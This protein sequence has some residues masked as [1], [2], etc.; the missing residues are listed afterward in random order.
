MAKRKK[1]F[2]SRKRQAGPSA[3][4]AIGLPQGITPA[5]AKPSRRRTAEDREAREARRLTQARWKARGEW[6]A[7]E[8]E[9]AMTARLAQR[10]STMQGKDYQV[11][12]DVES[13]LRSLFQPHEI[14]AVEYSCIGLDRVARVYGVERAYMCAYMEGC[15]QGFIEGRLADLKPRRARSLKANAAKRTKVQDCGGHMMTLDERDAAIVTQYPQLRQMLGSIDA[16][17]RLAEKYGLMSREQVG[18]ILRKAA[19]SKGT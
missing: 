14:R 7:A 13:F 3:G 17:L 15:R 11:P 8:Q 10:P 1:P 9:A 5:P 4:P 19:P 16:Q 2:A 6:K 12:P 18:N